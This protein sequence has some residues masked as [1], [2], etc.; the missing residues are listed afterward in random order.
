MPRPSYGLIALSGFFA[1]G[2][3]IATTACIALLLPGRLWE[4]MWRLNPQAHPAFLRMGP[5]AIALMATV[6]STC[7]LAAVGLWRR[8]RWGHRLALAILVVNLIGDATNALVRGDLRTLIGIPIGA[9]L[10]AYLLSAA[11]RRQLVR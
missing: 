5:W 6:A 4:P 8:T 9:A 7:A 10:I 11:V 1:L 3:L 2:A